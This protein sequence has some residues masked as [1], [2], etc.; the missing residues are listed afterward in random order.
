MLR[1]RGKGTGT[2]VVLGS[3]AVMRPPMLIPMVPP[4]LVKEMSKA[5]RDS[6][7]EKLD[8]ILVAQDYG[9]AA[10]MALPWANVVGIMTENADPSIVRQSLPTVSGFEDLLSRIEDD[11]L[12]LLDADRGVVLVDPDG[13]V[14]ASYQAERER[15]SPRRRVFLDYAHQPARTL[16]GK[17]IRV[18]ASANTLEE[19]RG[20]V[21]S[22]A[23]AVYIRSAEEIVDPNSD[24][25]VQYRTL[26]ELVE[27]AS[28]KPI[29]ISGDLESVSM[30]ALMWAA[31]R[32]DITLVLSMPADPSMFSDLAAYQQEIREQFIAEEIDFGEVRIGGRIEMNQPGMESLEDAPLSKLVLDVSAPEALSEMSFREWLEEVIAMA[33]G[34]LL[35][36][37]MLLPIE[38]TDDTS[39]ALGLG[40]SGLIL[41]PER[42]QEVKEQIR[43]LSVAEC[44][45]SL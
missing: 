19:V 5:E 26:M 24:D 25:E 15:L 9:M 2:G 29:T 7:V 43:N 33:G 35:P 14:L 3:A 11:A 40:A 21:D 12:L 17:E 38:E 37:E 28:G 27:A 8:I 6:P 36:V 16:D 13:M 20:A 44:R 41:E 42:V 10:N 39:I 18:I 23:D 34:M 31:A 45:E 30:P 1:L 32:A 4:R 22:G